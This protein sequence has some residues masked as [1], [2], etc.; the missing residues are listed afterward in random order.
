MCD[1]VLNLNQH[2]YISLF[3]GDSMP[4]RQKHVMRPDEKYIVAS[5]DQW[6]ETISKEKDGENVRVAM[7]E[8]S[9]R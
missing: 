1:R 6:E 7:G 2:P 3:F 8:T 5:N 9:F 4:T